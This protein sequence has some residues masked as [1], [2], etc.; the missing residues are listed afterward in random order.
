MDQATAIG[1]KFHEY[2]ER[3]HTDNNANHF[4]ARF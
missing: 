1:G 2:A 3:H 4:V